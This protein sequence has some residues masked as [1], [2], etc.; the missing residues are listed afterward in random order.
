MPGP[1]NGGSRQAFCRL[2]EEAALQNGRNRGLLVITPGEGLEQ[3]AENAAELDRWRRESG[4][5][6][7]VLCARTFFP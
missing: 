6:V 3:S 2:I 7:Q 4:E 1:G 5:N